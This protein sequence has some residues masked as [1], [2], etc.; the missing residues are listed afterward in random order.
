[1][2]T[3]FIPPQD[4]GW[5]L[6][7]MQ[8]PD[9]ASVQRTQ[10]ILKR[11][12]DDRQGRPRRAAHHGRLRAVD[13][14][15][16][17]QLQLRRRCSSSSSRCPAHAGSV[18]EGRHRSRAPAILHACAALQQEMPEARDRVY[19]PPPVPGI[20]TAGGFKVMVEDRG[21]LGLPALDHYSEE[22]I[23]AA[24]KEPGYLAV[25]HGLQRP[26]AAAIT[27]TSIAPRPARWS[28]PITTSTRPWR[29]TS[30]RSTSTTST[31]SAVTGRS[32]QWPTGS[33]ATSARRPQPAQGAQYPGADG[34]HRHAGQDAQVNGPV[35]VLRYNLYEAAPVNGVVFPTLSSGDVIEQMDELATP[36]CRRR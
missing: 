30:A 15:D 28:V 19:P 14:P 24:R 11:V 26:D 33:S 7:D 36:S 35:M 17:Q 3:G 10:M 12:A 5:L 32:R 2:P 6:V 25:L 8:L 13:P 23:A 20:G 34:P 1:M 18:T 31:S 21:N 4:Q 16:G 27:W 22:Y 29:S 9:S